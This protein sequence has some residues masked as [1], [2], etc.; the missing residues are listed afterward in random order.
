MLSTLLGAI[1]M[2]VNLD[3]CLPFLKCVPGKGG[4]K[5]E[6]VSEQ[7]ALYFLY[8]AIFYSHTPAHC[9]LVE[10]FFNFVPLYYLVFVS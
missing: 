3:V 8:R 4:E 5:T 10:L 6:M 9:G 2:Q 1:K 7:T